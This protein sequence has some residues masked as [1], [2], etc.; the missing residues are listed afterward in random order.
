[1]TNLLDRIAVHKAELD[2]HKLCKYLSNHNDPASVSLS[3]VPQ[4]T[5]FVLG[6]RDILESARIDSPETQLEHDLNNHCEEDSEHWLWFIEDLNTLGMDI[7]H[8]GGNITTILSSIWSE[9]H[10]VVR[11][12]VYTVIHHIKSCRDVT[13]KL[14]IIDCLEAAFSSFITSLNQTTQKYGLFN[15]LKYFGKE[16]YDDEASHKIGSWIDTET[17]LSKIPARDMDHF[18]NKRMEAVV[19]E[20]FSGFDLIFNDW[21]K[22]VLTHSELDLYAAS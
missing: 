19:D 10:Y 2:E 7:D 17:K 11:K 22:I 20:I 21:Y 18:S 12:L 13:E 9:E 1:M 16:H 14:V 4:M 6:F 8:W 15:I 5:F 3:F